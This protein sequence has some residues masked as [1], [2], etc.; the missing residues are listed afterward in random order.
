MAYQSRGIF[1]M[2]KILSVLIFSAFMI[3]LPFL[4]ERGNGSFRLAKTAIDVPFN[5]AW[6]SD[7]PSPELCSILAKPF[8]YLSR[9]MQA[10]VFESEDG[11]FVIKLFRC[12]PKI[13]PW[14]QFIRKNFLNRKDK[15]TPEQKIELLFGACTLAY[16]EAADLTGL[17][18]I[19]LNSTKELLE[20]TYLVNRM[21]RKIP[22][23][24]NRCRFAIQKK[25][26]SVSK[27]FK[28]A[29]C[30]HDRD[31]Y[32]RLAQ[33]FVSLVQERASRNISNLDQKLGDN[34][35]FIG[36]QAIEWDFGRYS[37]NA[38]LKEPKNKEA[39]IQIFTKRLQKFLNQTSSDWP[40]QLDSSI[41]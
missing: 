5:P 34:F 15:H 38:N 16:T 17:V 41:P 24:L 39:E 30:A 10:F 29:I 23:D 4:V 32:I 11:Q 1:V 35:G 26:T 12:L 6:E 18:Y 14:R 28:D 9:G 19:H 13:H 31:K 7:P 20:P 8:H 36:E 27:A 2:R 21:G 37:F 40:L 33:S 25:G 22:V 3:Y